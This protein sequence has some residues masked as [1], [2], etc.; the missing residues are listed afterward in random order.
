[1]ARNACASIKVTDAINIVFGYQAIKPQH[2]RLA[3]K[4]A[5]EPVRRVDLESQ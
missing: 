3:K 1:M 4:Q 2:V 5:F